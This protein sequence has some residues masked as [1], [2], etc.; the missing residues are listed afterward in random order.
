M[1]DCIHCLNNHDHPKDTLCAAGLVE[2]IDYL[3]FMLEG[4]LD[5]MNEM[6]GNTEAE[7]DIPFPVHLT[8]IK[9][10]L[11]EQPRNPVTTPT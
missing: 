9:G 6:E 2:R 8:L 4:L 3:E 11:S 5:R 10:G 1:Q 7:C